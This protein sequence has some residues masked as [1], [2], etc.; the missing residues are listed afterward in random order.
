MAVGTPEQRSW[1]MSRIRSA[2]TTPEMAVRRLV[3]ALGY[4]YRLHGKGKKLP[5]RPD[6]IFTSRRK[7]IFVHGCYWHVHDDPSCN[8]KNTPKSRTEYWGP[9]LEGNRA[10]DARNI[11]ALEEAGWS[12]L[13]IWE[14]ECKELAALQE[15]IVGFL[16]PREN[17]A[18]SRQHS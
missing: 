17:G 13:V 11:A 8:R 6:M 5:G 18:P 9:K 14:C 10:R 2:D 12:V 15:K 3:H 4:R 16:G 7:I 1:N